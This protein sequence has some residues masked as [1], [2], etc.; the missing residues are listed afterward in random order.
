M[1]TPVDVIHFCKQTPLFPCYGQLLWTA[2]LGDF[3]R[4]HITLQCTESLFS[5]PLC[6]R[7]YESQQN[8][9]TGERWGLGQSK[10]KETDS[11]FQS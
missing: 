4:D 3:S 8:R 2:E 7:P 6:P 11:F 5:D 9:Q 1:I 10:P